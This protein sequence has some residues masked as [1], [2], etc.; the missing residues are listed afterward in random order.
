MAIDT[1]KLKDD[2]AGILNLLGKITPGGMAKSLAEKLQGNQAEVMKA[3]RIIL[4]G[5]APGR[6]AEAVKFIVDRYKIP[7]S[8]AE[9][10]VANEMA[11][12]NMPTDPSGS[13][14]EGFPS[15]PEFESSA[16]DTSPPP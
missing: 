12:A 14:D 7:E 2:A 4:S 9:R 1:D 3:I 5:T 15:R 8:V 13:A 16:E 11:D 6:A 10:L